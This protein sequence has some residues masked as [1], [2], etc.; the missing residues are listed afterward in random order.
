M[1]RSPTLSLLLLDDK[2]QYIYNLKINDFLLSESKISLQFM[3]TLRT[4]IDTT[5]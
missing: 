3:E 4:I 2:S 1:G 5:K